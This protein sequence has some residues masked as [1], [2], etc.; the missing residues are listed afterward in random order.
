MSRVALQ[1][2]GSAGANKHYADTVASPVKLDG[3]VRYLS[4]SVIEQLRKIY[5]SGSA[6]VWGVTPG[7]KGVNIGKWER[8][9]PGDVTLFA[10]KGYVFASAVV[11]LKLHNADLARSLWGEDEVG[12]T[13]EY[14]YFLDEV[15]G[16]QIPY[17]ALNTAAGYAPNNVIQG[18]NV[19]DEAKS[20]AIINAFDLASDTY[21]PQMSVD[22]YVSTVKEIDQEAVLD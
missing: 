19:L 8:L 14:V 3:M 20:D 2:A 11:S 5:P 18:F 10:R 22:D 1:P 4:S 6:A 7:N 15:K 13:W 9:E 16:H 21:S 12:E 17:E